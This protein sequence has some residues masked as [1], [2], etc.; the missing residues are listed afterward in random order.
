MPRWRVGRQVRALRQRRGWRQ[1]DLAAQLGCSRELVSRIERDLID[2]VP[3]GKVQACVEALGGY[4][5]MDVHWQGERLPRLLD[6]RHA[7][8]QNRFVV[9]LEQ[10]G[11]VVRV[12][13]SFNDYGDRGRIDVLAHHPATSTLAVIE[14]KPT[15][16]DA[17]DAIGRLDAKARIAPKIVGDFGWRVETVVPVLVLDDAT[18]PRRHVHQHAAL[19]RRFDRRGR[20]ATAWLRR[21]R[22]SPPGG[23]MLFLAGPPNSRRSN[24][25]RG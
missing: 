8:L 7:A 14:I 25:K 2:N 21:P 6:A 16:G 3:A 10:L 4:L 18:T 13:V 17:Q 5:R 12:E 24:M 19:F 11:W 22:G 9:F 20:A 15:I 1:E 23:L